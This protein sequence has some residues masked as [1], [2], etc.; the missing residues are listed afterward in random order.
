VSVEIVY[1][2]H[3]ITEDNEQGVATGWLPGRLS[4]AG[5]SQ[6]RELGARRADDGVVAVFTSDLRRAVETVELAFGGTGPP[7]LCDWRLRECDYGALNGAPTAEVH[8]DRGRYLDRPY[9]GGESWRQ[10]IA[11]VG[12]ALGDL[13]SRWDG[14]RLL[15]VGHVA[16]RWALDHL[17]QGRPL[18]ELS[19]EDFGWQPG[20]EYRWPPS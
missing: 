7:V 17:V 16:T 18:E 13:P 12:G 14:A 4:P 6:A 11:R 1:E 9:P 20:W 8:G 19:T 10:A 15:V 5:R 3:G 2:T